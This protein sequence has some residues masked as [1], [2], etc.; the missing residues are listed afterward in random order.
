MNISTRQQRMMSKSSMQPPSSYTN[1]SMLRPT[2][3]FPFDQVHYT[4]DSNPEIQIKT[5]DLQVQT[6]SSN[7]VS[8]NLHERFLKLGC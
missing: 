4:N 3:L 6:L 7:N 1:N 2:M 5:I 8:P